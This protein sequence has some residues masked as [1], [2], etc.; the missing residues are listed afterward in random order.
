MILRA[1]LQIAIALLQDNVALPPHC[2]GLEL[3][4]DQISSRG[5]S[6]PHRRR[7]SLG[8]GLPGFLRSS[9]TASMLVP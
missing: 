1:R 9:L 4:P 8:M 6:P 7:C 2:S 5:A 3:E